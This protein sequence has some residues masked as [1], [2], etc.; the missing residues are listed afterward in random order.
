MCIACELGF[1]IAIDE[2]P[3]G[4]RVPPDQQA[5]PFA[6]DVPEDAAPAVAQLPQDERKP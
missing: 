6:C 1:W 4:A 2:P 5:A 3:A